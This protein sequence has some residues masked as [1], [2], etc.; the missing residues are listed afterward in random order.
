[1]LEL[2]GLGMGGPFLWVIWALWDTG[3]FDWGGEAAGNSGI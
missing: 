2:R 1:M 3:E